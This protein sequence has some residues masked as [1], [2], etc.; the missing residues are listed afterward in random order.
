MV[1][2]EDTTGKVASL[3]RAASSCSS[4]LCGSHSSSSSR[5]AIHLPLAV[6]TPIFLA[7]DPPT[8]TA[9]GITRRRG[10]SMPARSISV[11]RSSPSITTIT[12]LSVRSSDEA[13][14]TLPSAQA[15]ADCALE[16]P[17]LRVRSRSKPLH[18]PPYAAKFHGGPLC[19]KYRCVKLPTAYVL[20]PFE[21]HDKARPWN[22]FVMIQAL[23]F[24]FR[25]RAP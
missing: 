5:N 4:I 23:H 3:A 17:R 18:T 2:R 15:L 7:S 8:F 12:S 10:S 22:T 6:R 14:S 20:A 13:R 21:G 24:P 16:L 25:E 19:D 1:K 9:R 11:S